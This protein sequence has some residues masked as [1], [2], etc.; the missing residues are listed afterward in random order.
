MAQI[1]AI[2]FCVR[3]AGAV[4][5]GQVRNSTTAGSL[6]K[7]VLIEGEQLP[8]WNQEALDKSKNSRIQEKLNQTLL[9]ERPVSSF[10]PRIATQPSFHTNQIWRGRCF[11]GL[12]ANCACQTFCTPSFTR[13]EH[14]LGSSS[15]KPAVSPYKFKQQTFPPQAASFRWGACLLCLWGAGTAGT[16]SSVTTNFVQQESK[17]LTRWK[18]DK[19]SAD[20]LIVPGGKNVHAN[21]KHCT[22]SVSSPVATKKF[23]QYFVRKCF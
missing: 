23:V 20:G 14:L 9:R 12:W 11:W 16:F 4:S 7:K 17:G 2:V 22:E 5:S 10:F 15:R 21:A 13:P 6:Q 3:T 1:D 8:F 19:K 18:K